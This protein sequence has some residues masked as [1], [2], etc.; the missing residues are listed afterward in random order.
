M[1][2]K[3]YHPNEAQREKQREARQ[4]ITPSLE[5]HSPGITPAL[6]AED[7]VRNWLIY[8]EREKQA[9]LTQSAGRQR[10]LERSLE[11]S[12]GDEKEHTLD[13]DYGLQA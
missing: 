5:Q 9:E 1:R 2:R 12:I 7:S 13:Y 8:R 11:K 3:L 6:T 4:R 10:A